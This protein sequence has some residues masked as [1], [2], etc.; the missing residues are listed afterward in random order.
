MTKYSSRS[1]RRKEDEMRSG[2]RLITR[3]GKAAVGERTRKKRKEEESSRSI[4]K[5]E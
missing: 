3:K 1:L 5:E 2:R 4:R